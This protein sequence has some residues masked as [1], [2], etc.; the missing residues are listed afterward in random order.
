MTDADLAVA[1]LFTEQGRD[2][3]YPHYA[4]LHE[5]GP[6]S[7]LTEGVAP[8]FVAVANGYRVVDQVLRDPGFIKQPSRLDWDLEPVQAI[9]QQSMLF[10]NDPHHGRS[11]RAFNQVFTARRVA[12]LE[13]AVR[14]LVESA[15]DGLAKAGADGGVV[16]FVDEFAYELPAAVIGAMIGVDT[17]DITWLRERIRRI[18]DYLDL[19]GKQQHILDIANAAT[20]EL[21]EYYLDLVRRRRADPRDDLVSD[22]VRALAAG[23]HELADDELVANLLVLFNAGVVTTTNLL[24]NG[25]PYLL[26]SP[27]VAEAVCTEPRASAD[28][29]EEV[30]RY[31]SS[32][33]FL[34]RVPLADT[35][36]GGVPVPAGGMVFLL[37][38]AANRDPARYPD[39]DTFDPTRRNSQPIAFG[40]GPH[41]CIGAA[42][43]RLEAR[44]AFPMILE[45]FP[46]LRLAGPPVRTGQLLLRGCQSVPITL[47]GS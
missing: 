17:H 4:R 15:L 3:P 35:E 16:D 6:V 19:G 1:A 40:A 29:V 11:R 2:D 45:R 18:D 26:N 46:G 8:P 27:A 22:L 24:A 47:T 31:E 43:S 20:L 36:V 39:P 23:E 28:F 33:Q 14:R 32:V 34:G 41:F 25:L 12:E 37:L 9:L 13:P 5:L 38:G 10:S 21:S 7:P 30:L 42:L 44:L